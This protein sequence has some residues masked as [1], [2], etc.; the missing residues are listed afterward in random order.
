M[1]L[2]AKFKLNILHKFLD[3]PCIRANQK[4]NVTV[5]PIQKHK[6]AQK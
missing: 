5:F 2:Y 6:N 1:Y 4:I 3:F